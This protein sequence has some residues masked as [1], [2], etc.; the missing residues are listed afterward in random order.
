MS[1]NIDIPNKE[2]ITPKITILGVGGAGGNAVNNM[3]RLELEGVNFVVANTDVQ[4]LQNSNAKNKIQLGENLTKG[5]GAGSAP[6]IGAKASIESQDEIMS[7]IGDSNMVFITAGMGGG[8]GTGAAPVIAQMCKD[9]GILTVGVITKPFSFEGAYRMKTAISG[10]EELQ[11]YVDTLIIIPNQNLFHKATEKTTFIEAFNMVDDVLYSG[12][13]SIT[14]LMIVDGLI[15]LDF[16]DI[17]AIMGNMGKAMMGTGEAAGEQR[18]LDAAEIAISNPL[19]DNTSMKGARG[20][21]ISIAG[22]LDLGLFE[23]DEAAQRIKDEVDSEANIIFGSTFDKSLDGKIRV[24]VVATG[25]GERVER[26][27]DIFNISTTPKPTLETKD[28]TRDKEISSGVNIFVPTKTID[29]EPLK[30]EKNQEEIEPEKQDKIAPVFFDKTPL[31]Y[32]DST[33]TI[34]LD[35]S[36]TEIKEEGTTSFSEMLVKKNVNDNEPKEEIISSEKNDLL[37]LDRAI[38]GGKNYKTEKKG[39]FSKFIKLFKENNIDLPQ[40]SQNNE[41][42]KSSSQEITPQSDLF[43]EAA[44]NASKNNKSDNNLIFSDDILNVPTF[45]RNKKS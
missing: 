22:G 30:E 2:K 45:I 35:T 9:K 15:N 13:K 20:V 28:E 19:L 27:R 8:T 40:S 21:L 17:K 43:S 37:D 31:N 34:D 24:S 5:L 39:T 42:D 18:A 36:K 29:P 44:E 26:P 25:I 32:S 11:K 41:S 33:D 23:V 6:E 7:L 12:I 38:A 3:I 4:A 14:D 10:V 16:A 1:L